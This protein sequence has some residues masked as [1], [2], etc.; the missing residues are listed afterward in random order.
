MCMKS[1]GI[2]RRGHY[3][4]VWIDK[5]SHLILKSNALIESS[6]NKLIK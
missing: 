6:N 2:K 3:Q 5:K 4:Q 1:E